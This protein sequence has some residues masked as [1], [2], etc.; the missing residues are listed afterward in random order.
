MTFSAPV[1]LS[2]ICPKKVL[3]I[4]DPDKEKGHITYQYAN[5]DQEDDLVHSAER[6]EK[7][8]ADQGA[9]ACISGLHSRDGG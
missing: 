4:T 5:Q 2:V 9:F 8:D 1:R 6:P 3:L 7:P